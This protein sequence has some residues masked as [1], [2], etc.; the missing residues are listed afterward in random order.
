MVTVAG[1]VPCPPGKDPAEAGHATAQDTCMW[2]H[3]ADQIFSGRLNEEWP[4]WSRQ[5]QRV[6]DACL[7]SARRRQPVGISA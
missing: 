4:Q 7:E 2:R 6:L 5:T 1:Q 3:F